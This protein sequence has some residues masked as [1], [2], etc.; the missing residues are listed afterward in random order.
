[1][2][3]ELDPEVPAY[4]MND[5]LRMMTRIGANEHWYEQT[6]MGV[7]IWQI[8]GDLLRLQEVIYAVK[9]TWIVETGTKFGGSALFFSSLLKLIGRTDG[10]VVTVDLTQ[11][12]EARENFAKHPHADLVKRAIIGDAASKSVVDQIRE[13]LDGSKERVVVFLD[14]NHNADH[15]LAEMNFYAEF[16]TPG[17]YM[18]VADTVFEDLA[19]TPV[20]TPTEK[21]PD[22]ANSNPRVAISRFLQT[23]V[24]FV[25]DTRF[26]GKGMSNFADGFLRKVG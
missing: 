18:I 11:Y 1:M 9:P 13:S 5:L 23:R 10:G 20:G 7:P 21:Y 22:V 14:D 26:A 2:R 4:L 12:A 25:R 16:V 8:P 17:S 15:V 6:W 3:T 19:G 24:D